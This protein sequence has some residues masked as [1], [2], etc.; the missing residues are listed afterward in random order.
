LLVNNTLRGEV[1]LTVDRIIR[2]EVLLSTCLGCIGEPI[3][4]SF[5][6]CFKVWASTFF[7]IDFLF[8]SIC[9]NYFGM[10]AKLTYSYIFLSG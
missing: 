3:L 2:G 8:N 1:I 7:I 9:L 10:N 6:L 4:L 5:F